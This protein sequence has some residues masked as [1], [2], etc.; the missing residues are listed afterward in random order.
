MY[1]RQTKSS[2]NPPIPSEK[3]NRGKSPKKRS[4]SSTALT[5]VIPLLP[6]K[7]N[8]QLNKLLEKN[9]DSKKSKLKS[10]EVQ[11]KQNKVKSRGKKP[12]IIHSVVVL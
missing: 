2:K 3:G 11:Q 8:T 6:K 4:R 12:I 7:S 10:K 1:F 5:D 9:G